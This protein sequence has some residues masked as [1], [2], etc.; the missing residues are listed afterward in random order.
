MILMHN[1]AL[2][3]YKTLSHLVSF[4]SRNNFVR[5]QF[6][7]PFYWWGKKEFW[8]LSDLSRMTHLVYQIPGKR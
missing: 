3:T 1:R 6:F 7:Y 2:H 8:R 5:L 4:E